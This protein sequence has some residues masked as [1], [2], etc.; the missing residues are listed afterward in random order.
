MSKNAI[1]IDQIN[2]TVTFPETVVTDELVRLL[3]D[4]TP[5]AERDELYDLIIRFGAFAYMDDRIG[6]FLSSTAD[7]VGAK[8]EYLKLLYAER[9]RSM[10]TAEKGALAEKDVEVAFR[11]LVAS[12]SWADVVEATGEA[13]GALEG[14]KT[15]DVVI[16]IGGQGGPRIA[17]EVKFDKNTALGSAGL[18]KH[19]NKNHEDTAWSQLVEAGANREASLSLIVFDRGSASP[20]VKSAVQD[21]AWLPGAG[22]AVMVDAEQGDFSNLEVA[23]GFA[24]G[25]LLAASRP[26]INA[27][28]LSVVVS[29]A[30]TEVQRCLGVRKHVMTIM[31]SAQL[32]MVDLE[33]SNAALEGISE[34]LAT[35][36]AENPLGQS[37]LLT[38][39]QGEDVRDARKRTE[40]EMKE[41]GGSV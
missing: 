36:S 17:V 33:Q 4:D 24:R 18:A 32:M 3:F 22:L 39:D 2:E 28:L 19:E 26:D 31:K 20:T 23:Y 9:Q 14:N 10:A 30:M 34:M 41:L 13:A 11:E 37:D 7:D 5:T 35:V 15:G 40:K 1:R 27:E 8:F 29:R 16:H 6:A 21:V 25:L 38:L 12:R